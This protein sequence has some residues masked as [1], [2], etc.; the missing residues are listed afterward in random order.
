MRIPSKRA[1]PISWEALL[2]PSGQGVRELREEFR[3]GVTPREILH[4]RAQ[5]ISQGIQFRLF[6]AHGQSPEGFTLPDLTTYVQS[7]PDEV[8]GVFFLQGEKVDA[9]LVVS[10]TD[11]IMMFVTQ[12]GGDVRPAAAD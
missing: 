9:H 10:D 7:Q 8:L 12:S 1:N 2:P 6:D 5:S 11:L 4:G 3:S